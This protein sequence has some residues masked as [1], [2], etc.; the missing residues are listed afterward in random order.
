MQV[1]HDLHVYIEE[2]E[3]GLLVQFRLKLKG[4]DDLPFI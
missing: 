4:K 1:T 3:L 2:T